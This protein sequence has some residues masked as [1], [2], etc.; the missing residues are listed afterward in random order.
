VCRFGRVDDEA[1][2]SERGKEKPGGGL[3]WKLARVYFKGANGPPRL[4]W[5][6]Q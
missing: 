4:P 2:H 6:T 1:N 3:Q 5:K